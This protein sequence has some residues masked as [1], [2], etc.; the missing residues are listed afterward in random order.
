M[1]VKAPGLSLGLV[2]ERLRQGPAAR[3][4]GG[5]DCLTAPLGGRIQWDNCVRI[6]SSTKRSLMKL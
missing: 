4:G 1:A 3:R 6:F 5:G 2:G